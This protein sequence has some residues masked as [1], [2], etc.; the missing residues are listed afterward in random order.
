M[1]GVRH[2][3]AAGQPHVGPLPLPAVGAACPRASRIVLFLL[4]LLVGACADHE[5][6][7]SPELRE[8]PVIDEA[9]VV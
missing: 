6:P 1:I 4:A 3:G 5:D 7:I 2:V 8:E 9:F